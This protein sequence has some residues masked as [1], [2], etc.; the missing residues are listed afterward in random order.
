MRG[1]GGPGLLNLGNR[2]LK[3][4]SSAQRLIVGLQ[5]ALRALWSLAF[6]GEPCTSLKCD[7][8]KDMGWQQADPSS[9]FRG[10][11]CIALHNLIWM[12]THRLALFHRLLHKSVGT[13]SE[14][15]Y[16]FAAAGVNVT[17]MLMDITGLRNPSFDGP[18]TSPAGECYLPTTTAHTHT[19]THPMITL[20]HAS[21]MHQITHCVVRTSHFQILTMH[22]TV[23]ESALSN[24]FICPD[25]HPAACHSNSCG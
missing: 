23:A 22:A 3:K 13:R 8:W 12:A 17:F 14:W 16:P 6:P 18:L 5:D 20:R 1:T 4:S 7:R 19:H 24:A 21:L 11:G 10:G 25:H 9:D 2:A 15:E